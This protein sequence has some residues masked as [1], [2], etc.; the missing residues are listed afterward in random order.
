MQYFDYF[1]LPVTLRID[2]ALLRKRFL[3]LSKAAHPDRFTLE[4]EAAQAAALEQSTQ[5]NN[6]YQTLADPE[7][8]LHYLLTEWGMLGNES[9]SS[10][11]KREN[12]LPQSFLMEML[13]L[14]DALEIAN[15][16]PDSTTRQQ[17]LETLTSEITTLDTALEAGVKPLLDHPDLA[18]ASPT[19]RDALRV[20]YLKRRY[21]RRLRHPNE[22]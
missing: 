4:G 15:E 20:Y 22:M 11:Q 10:T 7:T 18:S 2:T 13:E 19:E 14:N 8:R 12:S 17:Q 3:A 1:E 16:Q 21:L 9:S 5:L 6:A